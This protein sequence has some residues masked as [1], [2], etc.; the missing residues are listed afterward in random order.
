M[1]PSLF[2]GQSPGPPAAIP[3]I[4]VGLH[5]AGLGDGQPSRGRNGGQENGPDSE[6][7]GAVR[8][9]GRCVSAPVWPHVC[10]A[11]RR[12]QARGG[13]G[14]EAHRYKRDHRTSEMKVPS[15]GGLLLTGTAPQYHQAAP[16]FFSWE[17]LQYCASRISSCLQGALCG[18]ES[19]AAAGSFLASWSR[20]GRSCFL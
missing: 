17:G 1:L 19:S 2:P 14:S 16:H 13:V 6:W 18:T 3:Q 12:E 20:I 8:Q 15:F 5:R 4:A 11:E 10:Q 9:R 7:R